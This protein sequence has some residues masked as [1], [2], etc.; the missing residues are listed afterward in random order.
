MEFPNTEDGAM[1]QEMH[2]AGM[3][4]T[5]SYAIDFFFNFKKKKDAEKMQQELTDGDRSMGLSLVESEAKD[6]W[7]LSCALEMVPTHEDLMRVQ[8]AFDDI[9]AECGGESDGWGVMQP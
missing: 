4:L 1:L 3:D 9:A 2:E 8:L 5:M 7:V 6:G